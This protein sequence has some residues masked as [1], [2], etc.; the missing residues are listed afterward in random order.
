MPL[1]TDFPDDFRYILGLQEGAVIGMAD[2]FAQAT[3]K[4]VWVNLHAA[5]GTG[6]AMGNLTNTQAGHVPAIVISGQQARRYEELGAEARQRDHR[7]CRPRSA[8]K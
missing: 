4:P 7:G 5:A 1:L 6:D 8:R 2:G 3:G